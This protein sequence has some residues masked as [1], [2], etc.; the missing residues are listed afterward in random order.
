VVSFDY[1]ALSRDRVARRVVEPY[2]LF[3]LGVHWYLVG[4]DRDRGALRNFRLNRITAPEVNRK[5]PQ[6][7]DY[8]IPETFHLREH[9]CSRQAW[10]LGDGDALEALIEFRGETGA[11]AAVARL[12]EP[13]D[14]ESGA[15]RCFCVR[16]LDAFVRWLM[17][18]GGD[19]V[20]LSPSTLVDAYRDQVQRTLAIYEGRGHSVRHAMAREAR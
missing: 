15:C 11:A 16:R 13:I 17:S 7:A 1:H 6:T 19:A 12:G 14:G 20:P 5:Q 3:F 2:G 9:A 8:E 4:R 18:F 10:E